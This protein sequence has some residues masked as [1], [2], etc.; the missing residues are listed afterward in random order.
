MP[1]GSAGY[2]TPAAPTRYWERK[3]EIAESTGLSL[4]AREAV[5]RQRP[6]PQANRRP[7]KDSGGVGGHVADFKGTAGRPEL[8]ELEQ[9]SERNKPGRNV[10][11][12]PTPLMQCRE[13]RQ[14]HVRDRMQRLVVDV[15]RRYRPHRGRCGGEQRTDH[16]QGDQRRPNHSQ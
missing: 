1:M 4:I 6:R 8:S 15:K 9:P 5:G 12:P 10:S 3:R 7:G 2:R 16:Y 11:E 13:K 14:R